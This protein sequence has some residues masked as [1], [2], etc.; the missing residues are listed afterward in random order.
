MTGIFVRIACSTLLFVASAAFCEDRASEA[1]APLRMRIGGGNL[2]THLHGAP[3]AQIY[4]ALRGVGAPLGRMDS[5][6]WRTLDRKPTPSDF[7][8]AMREAY[9]RGITPVILLEYEGSYQF[10]DPPQPIGSYRDWFIAGVAYAR[11]FQPGGEWAKAN[12]VSGWGATIFTAINEPDVQATIPREEYRRALEGLAD[13]V[14]SV[15]RDLKVVPGGFATC[16]SHGDATLR[17]YGPAIAPLLEDGRLDGVDLHTYY[18]FRWFPLTRGRQFSAQSCFDRVKK[19]MGLSRDINFYA[20]EYNISKSEGWAR[21]ETA[22]KLFLTAFWDEM[23]VVGADG[24]RPATVLAMPW[25]L[26]DTGAIEG[27]SYAMASGAAPWRPEARAIVLRNLIALAGSMHFVS[28]DREKGLLTLEGPTGRLLVW[29]DLEGWTDAPGSAWTVPLPAWAVTAEL[30]GWDGL[31]R[32]VPV[33]GPEHRFAGL[34]PDETYMVFL[35][36]PK[37]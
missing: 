23:A 32:R 27:P 35:P 30:W 26:G 25:N 19:A 33:A 15:N 7:D 21:P 3:S 8:A 20:T 29:H 4:A 17:G 36:R 28:I 24:R 9:E 2:V 37:P 12:Q 1:D 11:R 5:Y 16:N 13:G 14:H 10:L 31:R 34:K 22:A 6:G 18:N